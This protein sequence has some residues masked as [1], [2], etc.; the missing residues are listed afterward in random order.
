MSAGS[1]A[2]LFAAIVSTAHVRSVRL[3]GQQ[4]VL[5]SGSGQ[6]TSVEATA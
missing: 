5:I 3:T 4:Q 2:K 6:A 1:F